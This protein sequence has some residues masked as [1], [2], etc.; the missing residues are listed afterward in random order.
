M[1][2]SFL[3]DKSK[4]FAK[5]IIYLCRELK[6]QGVEMPVMN[7]L[8]RSGTSIGANV[9]EA[10]FAQSTKDFISKLEIAL[11]ECNECEYW[12]ELINETNTFAD[13]K[14]EQSIASCIEIRKLLISSVKTLKEQE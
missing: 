2:R 14:M 13:T 10:Q 1:T 6:R 7:Q 5:E 12:L 8:L 9:H 3:R 4:Q 11:K